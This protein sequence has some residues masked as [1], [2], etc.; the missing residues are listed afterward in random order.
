MTDASAQTGRIPGLV[1]TFYSYKGG[2]GRSMAMANVGAVMAMEGLRVL[3]VDFDLEAPGLEMFY[4]QS[5]QLVGDP[6][7]TPGIVDLLEAKAAG[8]S[9]SWDRCILKAQFFGKSLDIISAGRKVDNYRKRVQTLDWKELFEQHRIGN[10]IDSLRDAWR[11][12]YDIVLVDS[13]TGITDIGDICTVILPDILVL[14]FVANAQ[15]VEGIRDAIER[16]IKARAKLPTNR[17]K[18]MAVPIPARDERDREYDKSLEWQ[19]NYAQAFGDLYQEWLP[20]E[21]RAGDALN[22]LYIPYV[23]A[24]SFGERIPVIE[25]DRERSDPSSIGAAYSR[26]A[27]LLMHRLDWYAIESKASVV[28][29]IGTRVELSKAR[30]EKIAAEQLVQ[31]TARRARYWAVAVA[32]LLLLMLIGGVVGYQQLRRKATPSSSSNL[33]DVKENLRAEALMTAYRARQDGRYTDAIRYLSDAL[34]LSGWSL[35]QNVQIYSERAYCYKLAGDWNKSINDLTTALSRLESKDRGTRLAL[36]RDRAYAYYRIRDPEAALADY[37]E[38]VTLDPKVSAY[39]GRRDHLLKLV[40]PCGTKP[41]AVFLLTQV[42]PVDQNDKRIIPASLNRMK[43][44]T[45]CLSLKFWWSPVSNFEVRYTDK[46][47]GDVASR[48]VALLNKQGLNVEGPVLLDTQFK[49]DRR[50]EVW[51]PRPSA[52]RVLTGAERSRP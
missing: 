14:M 9:L 24:W 45:D 17:S 34:L 21:V 49:R 26:L 41:Y 5:A 31:T 23:A 37:Q 47:D 48:I 16:A 20:K 38:I 2:V 52:P 3:L 35:A 39:I 43:Q 33:S 27:T 44:F 18:L 25:S 11:T 46:V 19:R 28:E 12:A 32:V 4:R 15:N 36:L 50:I 51:F 10:Y 29:I 7:T 6:A 30:E 22:K 8:R 1:C 13:R 42:G 40:Q